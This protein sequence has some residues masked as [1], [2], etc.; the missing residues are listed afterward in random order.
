MA[1]GICT[2]VRK[3]KKKPDDNDQS[4]YWSFEGREFWAAMIRNG[5]MALKLIL[6]M[7]PEWFI[8]NSGPVKS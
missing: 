3:I 7:A 4:Q 1:H 8:G 2:P 5:Y 6:Y